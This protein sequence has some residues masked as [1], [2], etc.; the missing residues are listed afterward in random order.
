M[1]AE[2]PVKSGLRSY[3][4]LRSTVG[5]MFLVSCRNTFLIIITNVYCLVETFGERLTR[6]A[7]LVVS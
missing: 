2:L 6:D 3:G 1:L 4:G 7:F 5:R